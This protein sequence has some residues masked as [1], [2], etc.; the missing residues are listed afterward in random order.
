MAEM[1][2]V[3]EPLLGVKLTDMQYTFSV[4]EIIGVNLGWVLQ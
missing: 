2:A 4:A 3:S 1:R